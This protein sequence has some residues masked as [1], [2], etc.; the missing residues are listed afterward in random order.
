MKKFNSIIVVGL[1]VLLAT[2]ACNTA[3]KAYRKGDYYK[4]TIEAIARLRNK[5]DDSKAQTVLINAYPMAQKTA[6]R[7]I[8]NANVRDDLHKYDIMVYQYSRLNNIA[9]Q[10]YASPK[11]YE[12]IPRPAEY[13]AEIADAKRK[14]AEHLYNLGE[15]AL[16]YRTLEQSRIAYNHF[17]RAN[18]YVYGYKD[19]FNKIEESLYYA[20]LRVLVERPITAGKYQLSAEFFSNNLI[21]EMTRQSQNKFIRFYTMEEAQSLKMNNPHQ[22]LIFDFTDYTIGNVRE[23]INSQELKRDSVVVGTV[24]VDGKTYNAYNTVYA[25]FTTNRR[26]ILSAGVLSVRIIDAPTNRIIQH[27][28]FVGEY[29]WFTEWSGYSGDERALTDKQK[30]MT[31]LQP[32]LP[33]PHQDL[34][35]EFTKPIYSQVLTFVRS[36]Y[37]NY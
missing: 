31:Q 3:Q 10:I 17:N 12:L 23:T 36:A 30:R 34:F 19:V 22:F 32:V 37:R 8:E 6:L 4:A 5:P 15:A 24:N 7:E 20:T 18:E 1:L 16:A 33:P 21:A 9:N 27:Q 14:A 28:N 25:K 26:E 35:I 29:V 13:Q 11:A 2:T